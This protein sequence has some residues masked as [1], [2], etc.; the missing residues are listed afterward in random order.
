MVAV[1]IVIPRL[2]D[3]MEEGT[4]ARWLV[5][6]GAQVV[7]GRPLVEIDTDKA[8]MEYEAED[9]GILLQILVREGESAAIGTPIARVGSPSEA[10]VGAKPASEPP[11]SSAR[12]NASPVAK[13]IAKELGVDLEGLEGTGPK[14]MITREDVES[15]AR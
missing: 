8:T 1:E 5:A 13:R 15:A 12:A 4:V 10:A 7:R 3:S 11:Q 2:S 9:E 14:G 6:E